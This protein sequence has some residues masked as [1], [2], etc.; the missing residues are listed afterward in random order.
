VHPNRFFYFSLAEKMGM[1]VRV[2][3]D[4]ISSNE[5][6]EWIAYYKYKNELD[7]KNNKGNGNINKNKTF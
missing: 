7:K 2:L 1:P 6:T 4:N 5:L 3:L